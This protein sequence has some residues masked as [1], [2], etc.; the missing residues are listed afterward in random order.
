MTPT[1]YP[2]CAESQRERDKEAL[3]QA[4]QALRTIYMLA[5]TRLSIE[6]HSLGVEQEIGMEFVKKD[7]ELIAEIAKQ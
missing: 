5:T 4:R 7:L 6:R 3:A 2:Q 1:G